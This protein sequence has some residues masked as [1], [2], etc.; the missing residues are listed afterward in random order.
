MPPISRNPKDTQVYI[1]GAGIAS[2][3]A[4]VHLIVDANVNPANIHIFDAARAP[5]GCMTTSVA[6]KEKLGYIVKATR[7]IRGTYHCLQDTLSKVPSPATRSQVD[8]QAET[9]SSERAEDCFLMVDAREESLLEY[10]KKRNV[11]NNTGGSISVR[12]SA[13]GADGPEAVNVGNF[14]L[15]ANHRVSLM[16]FL[17]YEEAQFQGTEVQAWF[18]P[19]FFETN[20]WDLWSSTYV[21]HP[22]HGAVEF[23]RYMKIFLHDLSAL[24]QNTGSEYSLFNDF[25]QVIEPITAFLLDRGVD[26]IVNTVVQRIQFAPD[27][28][29]VI[30]DRINTKT[31]TASGGMEEIDYPI[32][33]TDI[34]L[35]T[36]GS[37]ASGVSVGNNESAPSPRVW[38]GDLAD[39]GPSWALWGCIIE[40][41]PVKGSLGNPNVFCSNIARSSWLAFTITAFN[42]AFVSKVA[43]FVESSD[44]TC[45]LLTFRDCPWMLTISIPKQPYFRGQS[46]GTHIIWGYGLFPDQEGMFVK[47][48]MDKCTGTEIFQEL[49]GHMNIPLA[50]VLDHAVTIPVIMPLTGSP[51]LSTEP[52]D[53]PAVVPKESK[54]LGLMGQ[55]VDMERD[56][57]FT[58]EYSVRSA[59]TA[60]FELMGLDKRPPSVPGDDPSALVLG[61]FMKAIMT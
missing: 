21:F 46:D 45:P 5:G 41:C 10:L 14:A 57:A 9:P 13:T 53:R 30:V 26:F 7:K 2:L 19:D 4:A 24:K 29:H 6:R 52:D 38:T 3:S 28:Q 39:W 40:D 44:G 32:R 17:M 18:E 51:L 56:V 43:E 16:K 1:V 12:I 61:E 23:Q 36:L 22:W 35:V 59:Q 42:A 37:V 60:V 47:K 50:G 8:V 33:E 49:L 31:K 48:R 55:F 15:S 58:M 54:N 34:C 20:F 27:K 25:E 11:N